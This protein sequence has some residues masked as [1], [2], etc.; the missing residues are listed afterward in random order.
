MKQGKVYLV[1]G[2]PGDARLITVK[3]KEVLQVA[4]V[5]V[6]DRLVHPK[7]LDFAKSECELIYG[8]KLPKRHVMRQEQI[9]DLLVAKARDG[10]VVVRL[11]G[12]DPSVFGR[13]GEE[14]SQLE[15]AGVEYE[16]VPGITSGIAA[17]V[18][19]GI[20]VTHRDYG[21]SF[22]VVT[23]H[24]KAENGHPEVDWASISGIDTIAFYMGIA[25]LSYIS[26]KLVQHGKSKDT[27]VILIRWGTYSRQTSLQGTLATIADK[28]EQVQFKNPA[29]ILV[30][31]IVNLRD[32]MNWF[33][34]KPLFGRQILLART[35]NRESRL[36]K[37]LTEKGAEVIEFPKWKK[38]TVDVPNEIIEKLTTYR[39]IFFASS[40]SIDEFFQQIV[41]NGLDIR[42][43]QADFYVG[44]QKS[45]RY[46][47]ER[48]FEAKIAK[49]PELVKEE[50][51]VVKQ[52]FLDET[53]NLTSDYDHWITSY[54]QIDEKYHII[55]QQM[56]DTITFDTVIF[57]SSRSI[58][59]LLEGL[60]RCEMD[61]ER[62]FDDL[63]IS[64]LGTQ[65]KN[66]LEK[67]GCSVQITPEIPTIEALI[68][69]LI[70]DP[71]PLVNT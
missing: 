61:T 32:Q 48:G 11:K 51:L 70:A 58:P 71:K 27:P 18:Y 49:L 28:A 36:A 46:L 23:A 67:R 42:A 5:I 65:T 55:F 26:E 25:N 10:K 56:V 57:P 20:P 6:Y 13:V 45:E 44:S 40:E 68:Q 60:E 29:I 64:C 14:A 24:G 54:Q 21:T 69:T 15:E 9:N 17:P 39:A 35:S 63:T 41:A 19:A 3:G 1:G 7:L 52:A 12:G 16:I 47:H 66:A 22:T 38:Q 50:L 33:E 62:F 34:K 8:G 59:A 4:D 2:G 53:N 43:I 31:H 30:G 37:E